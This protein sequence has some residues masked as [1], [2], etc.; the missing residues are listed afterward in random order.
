MIEYIAN[1]N[2]GCTV[3]Q[4]ESERHH[5]F[6]ALYIVKRIC[7]EHLFTYD[8]YKKSIE[9]LFHKI[10][11]V[12]IVLSK[13]LILL[14]TERARNYENIWI[15]IKAIQKLTKSESGIIITLMSGKQ[16]LV[17]RSMK[18]ILNQIAFS[19]EIESIKVKHFHT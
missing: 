14:P 17:H 19:K 10:H 2:K 15:N 5:P 8:G 7:L 16:V 13:N 6:S 9:F 4:I 1:D 12:P 11:L 3:Y 18:Q